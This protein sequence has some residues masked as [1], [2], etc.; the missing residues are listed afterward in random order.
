[1]V[2]LNKC[3]AKSQWSCVKTGSK[4]EKCDSERF[5]ALNGALD[6]VSASMVAVEFPQL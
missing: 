6:F 4:E 5:I 1:M 3:V 2:R